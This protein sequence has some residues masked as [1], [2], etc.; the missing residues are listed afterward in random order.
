MR[1][2]AVL[3]LVTL[4][5]GPLCAQLDFFKRHPR[6]LALFAADPEVASRSDTGQVSFSLWASP[7]PRIAT[8]PGGAGF[9]FGAD[10]AVFL[11]QR[12]GISFGVGFMSHV[13]GSKSNSNENGSSAR[14]ADGFEV[15]VG[16]RWRFLRWRTGCLYAE[17]RPAFAG[18]G[19]REPIRPTQ[20]LGPGAYFGTEL[21]S[22][23]VRVYFEQGVTYLI[24]I[25]H[26]DAG[27]LYNGKDSGVGGFHIQILRI[28]LRFYLGRPGN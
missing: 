4:A 9:G 7:V 8:N 19:G 18:Y 26:S 16:A 5:S 10:V 13:V 1:W 6:Q 27:W 11:D 21:G 22:R 17:F 20:S 25:N 28:G 2:V 3:C 12:F 14:V 23:S 15:T 24:G